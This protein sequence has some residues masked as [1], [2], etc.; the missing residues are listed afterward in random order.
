ME[1]QELLQEMNEQ[2]PW[3]REKSIK[4]KQNLIERDIYN[5]W[6][7]EINTDQI[8]GIIGLRRVGK[9]TLIK[10]TIA[11]L[12]ERGINPK[13]ILYFSF[14]AMKKEE[15]IIKKVV[16]LY[17]QQIL[18]IIPRELKNKVFIFF[19]EIQ[20][21]QDWG[22]EIKSIYDKEYKI[23]FAISGSSSMNILKGSGESLV[24]RIN[25][26]QLHTFSFRE[27]L[28]YNK[29]DV[30]K[31]SLDDITFPLNSDK[32]MIYFN[33]YLLLGGFPELYEF[34][35]HQIKTKLK[36]MIDLTFYRD[37]VN[38]LTLNRM[39]VLEGL[40]YSIMKES[41]NI[42]NYTKLANSLNT[43]FETI[44]T[45]LGYLLS[46]F[47]IAKSQ[48][49]SFSKIK[50]MEKNV[51]IYL[52]DHAFANLENLKE[53]LKIETIIFNYC[54]RLDYFDLFYWHNRQK[55]EVDIILQSGKKI[56]PLE[57]KYKSKITKKDISGVFNFMDKFKIDRGVVITKDL[58]KV[59]KIDGKK[60]Q[61]IPC[62]L[63]LLISV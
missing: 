44:K 12:L 20:K 19:D 10:Q 54:R 59:E 55:K 25:I 11:N 32:I 30:E 2:N 51:K 36:T 6:I 63:F 47:L 18:K 3:W 50:S 5:D 60:I 35:G 21:I 9:S 61:Y 37:L 1:N 28:K 15:T 7:D 40:F 4:L 34:V 24:G 57:V 43:K 39:D 27:F 31:I 13:N 26:I 45:Y 56:I 14:D 41:G 23:K 49:F 46:S 58:F 62:W 38:I 48:F 53:G 29:L 22:E 16:N 8:S 17:F 42:V 52:S 33:K